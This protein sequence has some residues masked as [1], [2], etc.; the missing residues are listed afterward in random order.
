MGTTATPSS[1]V[2]LQL[3]FVKSEICPNL[4]T[5]Q[6][7]VM[8]SIE[9]CVNLTKV[10]AEL[11]ISNAPLERNIFF[12]SAAEPPEIS[13]WV[14]RRSRLKALSPTEPQEN[15]LH[16]KRRRRRCFCHRRHI[17]VA[18]GI[19]VGSSYLNGWFSIVSLNVHLNKETL[20]S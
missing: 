17:F 9:L 13:R 10:Y 8:T 4:P 14:T 18:L 5:E 2:T 16:Q 20:S 12:P 6:S 15:K 11:A 3:N 1:R 7:V 19:C